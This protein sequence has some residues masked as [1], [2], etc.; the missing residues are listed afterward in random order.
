MPPVLH[1]TV[2]EAKIRDLFMKE[3]SFHFEEKETFLYSPQANVATNNIV[4]KERCHF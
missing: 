2:T 3:M 1:A 4:N